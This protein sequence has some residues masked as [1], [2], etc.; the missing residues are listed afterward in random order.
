MAIRNY[1]ENCMPSDTGYIKVS[2]AA[3]GAAPSVYTCSNST[4]AEDSCQVIYNGTAQDA[5]CF[6]SFSV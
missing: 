2:C 4:C 1:A 5:S 6:V 3:D